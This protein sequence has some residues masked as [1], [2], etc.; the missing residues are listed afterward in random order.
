M[1]EEDVGAVDPITGET[2]REQRLDHPHRDE[3]VMAHHF[4]SDHVD[5]RERCRVLADR[6]GVT[7]TTIERWAIRF[8]FVDLDPERHSTTDEAVL[9][10]LYAGT[11]GD[12]ARMADLLGVS[13]P[14]VRKRLL[15]FDIGPVA[16]PPE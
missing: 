6:W 1:S 14:T 5:P 15:M 11:D 9:A 8:G 16:D 13:K 7:D 3:A 10:D 4:A 2:E 12:V